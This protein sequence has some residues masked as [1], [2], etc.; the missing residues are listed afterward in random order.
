MITTSNPLSS[1]FG[2]LAAR[3]LYFNSVDSDDLADRCFE[4][5]PLRGLSPP[6]AVLESQ[7]SEGGGAFCERRTL[8]EAPLLDRS[9]ISKVPQAHIAWCGSGTGAWRAAPR[10]PLS[11]SCG[12]FRDPWIQRWAG[13]LASLGFDLVARH[14]SSS[15]LV[16]LW[17]VRHDW[18]VSELKFQSSGVLSLRMDNS[19]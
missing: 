17:E 16:S 18:S 12:G 6:V 5:F 19:T 15:W 8:S 14:H 7:L 1:R 9:Y 11:A 10:P 3:R 2:A 13:S 4:S